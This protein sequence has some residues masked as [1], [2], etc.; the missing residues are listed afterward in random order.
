MVKTD[1]ENGITGLIQKVKEGRTKF[2]IMIEHSP[3]GDSQANGDAERA[4]QS[5]QGIARTLKEAREI[6][7][8]AEVL[9]THDMVIWLVENAAIFLNLFKRSHGGYHLTAF[10]RVRGRHSRI[11]LPEFGGTLEYRKK[12]R[13]QS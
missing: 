11:P 1:Q 5:V 3:V 10:Y 7:I 4:V 12:W 8:G 9:E 2:E 13:R 6:S